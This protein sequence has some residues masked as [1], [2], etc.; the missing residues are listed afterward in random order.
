M[1]VGVAYGDAMG[2]PCEFASSAKAITCTGDLTDIFWHAK[3][4]NQY[5]FT[6]EHRAAQVTDDAEM[7]MACLRVVASG[8]RRGKAIH[9]YH[10]LVNSGTYSI[11]TN[12]R[13]LL[14]GYKRLD[15]YE[16]RYSER[17]ATAAAIEASQSNGHLMR[18][19]PFA[20]IDDL[21]T[22]RE[23]TRLD[24]LLTNPSSTAQQAAHLYVES[25]RVC[26]DAT[27]IESARSS[28]RSL[29]QL[30]STNAA[31]ALCVADARASDFTRDIRSNRGWTLN[32]LSIALWV[33]LNALSFHDGVLYV[34][35]QGGDTDTNASIAGALLGALFGEKA[36]MD[37][38]TTRANIEAIM[39]CSP[40]IRAG[41]IDRDPPWKPRPKQYHPKHL[42]ALLAQQMTPAHH[43][44][45]VADIRR[46]QRMLDRGNQKHNDNVRVILLTGASRSGKSTLARAIERH[47]GRATT[48]TLAQDTYR[49]HMPPV[50]VKGRRC[51]E[52]AEFTDWNR[53]QQAV[54]DAKT[55]A[56]LVIVEGYT[57]C[58]G[59]PEFVNAA[60]TVYFIDCT[61]EQCISRRASFPTREKY[62]DQGWDDAEAYVRGCV[63]PKH[64]Q[65]AARMSGSKLC[66]LDASTT[67]DARLSQIV[68]NLTNKRQRC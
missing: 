49:L 36:M 40:E 27:D 42:Y 5:G 29:M 12:T 45:V 54:D 35:R 13:K 34:V 17:F 3:R 14:H 48:A 1:L 19:S 67:V 44:T 63:W 60:T 51:W 25:L 46:V 21:A 47:F 62:G 65:Y 9:A 43:D 56:S 10:D 31:L 4:T 41:K 18:A 15:M 39:A 2:A 61:I 58:D 24:T 50:L 37:D 38:P 23:V 66:R 22:R 53:L 33:V 64:E 11:G 68:Q 57:L 30:D 55:R 16:K 6:V 7:T 20:L 52:G 32:A 28:V 26:L 59:P 8:Y